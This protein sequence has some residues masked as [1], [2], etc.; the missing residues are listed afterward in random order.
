M[1]GWL[2]KDSDHKDYLSLNWVEAGLSLAK[3]SICRVSVNP[4]GMYCLLG[5]HIG[6][7]SFYLYWDGE[8]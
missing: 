5:I 1:G 4:Y 7:R 3:I 2:S 6:F 8:I